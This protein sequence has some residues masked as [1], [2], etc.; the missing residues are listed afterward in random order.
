MSS[1]GYSEAGFPEHEGKGHD[2]L[3]TWE[4]VLEAVGIYRKIHQG[5]SDQGVGNMS[6]RLVRW[7]VR[8]S[9]FRRGLGRRDIFRG[10]SIMR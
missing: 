10:C 7:Q 9:P 1:D 5:D 3:F 6:G 8:R 4:D 2:F